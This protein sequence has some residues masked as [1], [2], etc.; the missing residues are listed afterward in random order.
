MKNPS[1]KTPD[2]Q[3]SYSTAEIQLVRL[4][5]LW[6]DDCVKTAGFLVEDASARKKAGQRVGFVEFAYR[7]M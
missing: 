5:R 3:E 7:S 6:R 4:E 2:C 1:A